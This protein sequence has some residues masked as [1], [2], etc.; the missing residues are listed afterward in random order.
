MAMKKLFASLLVGIFLGGGATYLILS[1][2]V[3]EELYHQHLLSEA[4]AT[5]A[6]AE[7]Y[8]KG[9]GKQQAEFL[10]LVLNLNISELRGEM[11]RSFFEKTNKSMNGELEI[12]Q[13]M[14]MQ[15][16]GRSGVNE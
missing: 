8:L 10:S 6:F 11:N 4:R 14:L 15:L 1:K 2:I 5:R 3:H 13:D 12:S 9:N 7:I 16:Q